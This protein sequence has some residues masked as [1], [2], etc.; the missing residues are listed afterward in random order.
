MSS[1]AGDTFNLLN[2]LLQHARANGADAAEAI[3][4]DALAHSAGLRLGRVEM[5]E[6]SESATL[7]LRVFLGKKQ[8][9][10]S[11]SDRS[12]NTIREMASRAVAMA[13][14]APEDEFCGLA[15]ADQIARDWPTLELADAAEPSSETLIAMARE[16]EDVAR[17]VPGVTNTEGADATAGA[18]HIAL[19]TSNGFAGQYKRTMYSCSVTALAGQGT[20]MVRDY[21]Y[22]SRVFAADLPTPHSLGANAGER[23]VRLLNARKMPTAQ[24]PIIFESRIAGSLLSALARA[25]S[26]S[27]IARGTSFLRDAMQTQIFAPSITIVD[28]PARPRGHRSRP[29]DAEGLRPVR[30]E[31][32]KNGILQTWL[33]DLRSAR[34]LGLQS[35]GH[36][37]GG[38]GAIPSPSASNMY[39][40]AGSLSVEE[41]IKDIKQGF[42][43][44]DM[45][46]HGVN[47]VTGDYSQAASGFWIEDGV[48]AFPVHEM[49]I[50]GNLKEMFMHL[51]PANDLEFRSG[52][53]APTLRVEGMM[54]AG[55]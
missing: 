44:T 48:I 55:V 27:S 49:T 23:A 17:A 16:A 33:L 37:V 54:T 45:M 42:F 18:S 9:T 52:V 20:E 50:A 40:Q 4:V 22:A 51:T 32:V 39:M 29:F 6:R 7:G 35:T 1:T 2:D 34:K 28:D 38:P 43:V 10:V 25:I 3:K 14:L 11:A 46:G 30:R 13:K 12:P 53:D 24:V 36:A 41:L 15:N 21:D 26:G 47:G 31:V 8:A 19:A 5:I